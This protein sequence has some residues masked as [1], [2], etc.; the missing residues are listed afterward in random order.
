VLAAVLTLTGLC[1]LLATA[2]IIANKLFFV[3]TNE[4]LEI[5]QSLLPQNNCGACGYPGCSAFAEALL[6]NETQPV[7]CSVSTAEQHQTIANFLGIDVG[8]MEKQVARLACAGG[9]NVARQSV[10][11]QGMKNCRAASLVN[12][13]GKSCSWG[14]LGYGD[15]ADVCQFNAISMDK[16]RLPIVDSDLCTAC[17]DCVEV[18]PKNLFSLQAISHQLWVACNNCNAGDELLSSCQVA[19]TSCERCVFDAPSGLMTMQN[20]LP[21]INYTKSEQSSV[22]IQRCPT[23][24]IIW[25]ESPNQIRKGPQAK[26]IIRQSPL[27]MAKP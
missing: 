11:Y 1:L 12:G 20:N 10:K 25:F 9:N 17:G 7:R 6:N 24:A 3:Q 16:H 13:G 2:L 26:N 15:C 4:K 18:C 27:E 8:K 21:I 23:G 14:C 5:L 22:P 19:C